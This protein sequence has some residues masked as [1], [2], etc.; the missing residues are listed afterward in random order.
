MM[1][2]KRDYYEVLAVAKTAG[3]KEIKAAYRKLAVQYHPDRNPGDHEAEEKFK[4]AAEAY[5]VLSD[6]DKRARYDRFG[7]QGV[8]GA[9]GGGIDP[10]IFADFSDILGDLFGFGDAFGRRRGGPARGADLRYDLTLTFNEA[11]FG[12]ETTLRLP[13]L[14]GCDTCKGT[15]SASGAQPTPCRTCN[16]QGQVRYSQGF[17]TVARTCPQCNGEGRTVSDPCKTCRGQGRVE[18]ERSLKV[19]I[20]PGVD[21]GA[22][23]RLSGEGE[24]G[25]AGGPAGDLYVVIRVEAH[26]R[27]QRDGSTVYSEL[28]IGYP[29]AVLGAEVAVETLHGTSTLDIPAGTQPGREFRLR[30]QGIP[31]IDGHGKGDHIVRVAIEVPDPKALSEEEVDLLRRLAGLSDRPVKEEGTLLDKVKNLF[32]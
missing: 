16:G 6:A 24:Q 28:P 2:S 20:P 30:G 15:G 10:T 13:R 11:V 23:L 14:E 21:T 29:Q 19:Q 8:G 12:T 9:A 25:R 18:R 31:R 5:A 26:A 7:H 3:E 1:A 4:E 32:G 27:F 17:F 22:R